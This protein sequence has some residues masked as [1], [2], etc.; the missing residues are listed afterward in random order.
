MTTRISQRLAAIALMALGMIGLAVAAFLYVNEPRPPKTNGPMTVGALSSVKP[1]EKAIAS[2]SVPPADPKYIAIPNMRVEQARIIRLG[3]MANGQI[4]TPNNIFDTGWYENSVKPGQ[5]G[6]MFIFG[7][8]SSWTADG[9]FHNLNRLRPGDKITITRG[10]NR[11]FVYQVVSFK[12][13]QHDKVDMGAVLSPINAGKPGLSLMTCTG[14]II[15]GTS[16]F[17]ERLVVFTSLVND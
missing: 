14:E 5:P 9:V 12:V 3:H 2:Y 13:Y 4:A 6:A 1:S 10:D 8:V 11:R 17:T 15:K 7:H 16:E